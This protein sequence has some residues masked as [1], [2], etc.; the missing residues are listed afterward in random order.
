MKTLPTPTGEQRL[1]IDA[2]KAGNNIVITAGAGAAKSTTC[3]MIGQK[4]IK[5][6]LYI[7]FNAANRKE[8]QE[9]LK[10]LDIDWVTCHTWHSLAWNR[11]VKG[12]SWAK[13]GVIQNYWDWKEIKDIIA[14][15][16]G[17][18]A[19]P[20]M[21]QDTIVI[22]KGFC[23][24][25]YTSV[26]DYVFA[27]GENLDIDDFEN[28]KM[29]L[30]DIAERVWNV[31][32]HKNSGYKITPD[33]YLKVFLLSK[34]DL[35]REFELILLDEGQDTNPVCLEVFLAQKCQKIIVGDKYQ[36]IYKWRGAINAFEQI[37]ESFVQLKL[38][39]SFRFNQD[40]A[41]YANILLNFMEAGF[42]IV[43]RGTKT[44][45]NSEATIVRNNSTLFLILLEA[46]KQDKKIFAIAELKEMFSQMY[47]AAAMM[48]SQKKEET[49]YGQFPNKQIKAYGTWKNL[50]SDKSPEI[51]KIVKLVQT[52][53]VHESIQL[54]KAHLVEGQAQANLI[55]VTGHKSKGLEFDR[56][57]LIEDLL[58]VPRKYETDDGEEVWETD[59][60]MMERFI[61]EQGMNL[62]YVAITR[63]KVE[64][65]L[66]EPFYEFID[67]I[68]V[69][70]TV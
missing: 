36:S 61:A 43:G 62:L 4:Y 6:T 29:D 52:Y 20:E 69:M 41:D 10:E 34:P 27:E 53:N 31:L 25:S 15:S 48:F 37:P 26:V 14:K 64:L 11:I 67:K 55:V 50:C 38:T 65:A 49:E 54:I 30:A 24:S 3:F 9:T 42:E 63:A 33:I 13:Y 2:A 47:T 39:E 32:S 57:R 70:T 1:I 40:I 12:T 17:Y 5:E 19:Y 7:V 22:L 45:I 51:R 8:A 18:V 60:E 68:T 56:I 44:E 28:L 46:A 59:E 23:Q 21:V 58:P 66:S 16:K 35:S